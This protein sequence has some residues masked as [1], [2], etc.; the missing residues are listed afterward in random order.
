MNPLAVNIVQISAGSFVADLENLAS[1][2]GKVGHGLVVGGV[3]EG[4]HFGLGGSGKRFASHVLKINW[5]GQKV[6][7]YLYP[8]RFWPRDLEQ[9]AILKGS[10][11]VGLAE[12]IDGIA[13]G[14]PLTDNGYH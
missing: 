7:R 3:G 8:N 12:L 14:G 6:N 9:D 13:K 5:I 10:G 1:A 4:K 2:V 11:L